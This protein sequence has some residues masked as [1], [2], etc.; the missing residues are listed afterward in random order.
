MRVLPV[1]V[2]MVWVNVRV[3]VVIR[4]G[5]VVIVEGGWR[6]AWVAV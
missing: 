1:E 4:G 5:A 6:V 3:M 2:E